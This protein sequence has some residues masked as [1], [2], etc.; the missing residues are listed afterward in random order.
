MAEIT[1]PSL[2]AALSAGGGMKPAASKSTSVAAKEDARVKSARLARDQLDRVA[3]LFNQS[4]SG[5][6]LASLA[7]YNPFSQAN[8][9]FNSASMALGPLAKSLTKQPGDGT[10]SDGDQRLLNNSYIPN[11]M[12]TDSANLE[13]MRALRQVI[14]NVDPPKRMAAKPAAPAS[15]EIHYDAQG[16]RVR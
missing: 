5:T 1:D 7:E 9:S 8:S 16:R 15:R 12:D 6:G 13:R 14:D 11:S 2:L 4:Q 3:T 10:F